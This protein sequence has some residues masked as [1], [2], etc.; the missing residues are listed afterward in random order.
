MPDVLTPIMVCLGYSNEDL[1]SNNTVRISIGGSAVN[2]SFTEPSV[3]SYYFTDR[4]STTSLPYL[5]LDL[6]N[7]AEALL[8]TGGTWTMTSD[9]KGT[10]NVVLGYHTWNRSGG[11]LPEVQ[12]LWTHASTTADPRWFGFASGADTVV[13][14][15][16]TE[17]V[18][19]YQA[20]RLWLPGDRFPAR[21]ESHQMRE[22]NVRFIPF[23][24]AV[25]RYGHGGYTAHLLRLEKLDAL[26]VYKD[27]ASHASYLQARD[28][29]A[30]GD[31]HV[32]WEG[33]IWEDLYDTDA[34]L[35]VFQDR[36]SIVTYV[37]A[38]VVGEAELDDP[39]QM[40][41]EE[42]PAPQRYY[43]EILLIEE[44]S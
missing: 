12:I 14:S 15:T 44:G 39:R 33:G 13:A 40:W 10:G 34:P 4:S 16:V 32:S 2:V 36:G 7:A 24:G 8:G 11:A 17:L 42:R 30:S 38:Q 29:V 35:R 25:N 37:D 19:D 20:R 31:P 22:G 21:W 23:N 9:L 41:K 28:G 43:G 6:L 18:S 26:F 5:L 1:A 3:G 27:R